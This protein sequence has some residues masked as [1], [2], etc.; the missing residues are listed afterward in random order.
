[1]R[2]CFD[3][4]GSDPDG[5]LITAGLTQTDDALGPDHIYNTSVI[6]SQSGRRGR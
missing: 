5:L 4:L 1:M 2:A 3:G 6:L